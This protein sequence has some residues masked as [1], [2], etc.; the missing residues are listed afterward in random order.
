MPFT[1]GKYVCAWICIGIAYLPPSRSPSFSE[2]SDTSKTCFMFYTSNILAQKIVH[3][4]KWR[5][6]LYYAVGMEPDSEGGP[7]GDGPL[8]GRDWGCWKGRVEENDEYEVMI[9]R[10]CLLYC[11][12]LH[13]T[14]PFCTVLHCT[15]L[16]CTELCCT[17]LYNGR[18]LHFNHYNC[19]WN[20]ESFYFF[21]R[22][23]QRIHIT[24]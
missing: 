5:F 20:H 23:I 6:N 12:V 18:C 17:V 14:A 9:R 13:W 16:Y 4:Y 7:G 1:L 8:A 15:P 22:L 24:W 21:F 3:Q 19:Y 2:F 11:T 10:S